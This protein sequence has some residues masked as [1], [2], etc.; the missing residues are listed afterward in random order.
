MTRQSGSP[1]ETCDT[2]VRGSL[3]TP[4][5]RRDVADLNRQFLELGL[6][7]E[8]AGDARFA[9][10]EPVRHGLL[11]TDEVTRGR[12]AACP[13]TFFE[14]LL[15]PDRSGSVAEPGR[16]EDAGWPAAPGLMATRWLSFAHLA[17]FLAWRLA[18]SAPLA[19]RIAL[20]LSPSS[21]LRLNEMCPS[22]LV[23]LATWPGLIRPRWPAHL[24]F[25]AMLAG[26]GRRNTTVALQ[27]AHCVGIC[28][29]GADHERPAATT[30]D[31]GPRRKP[32]R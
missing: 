7:P 12:M 16:V 24:Q 8:L 19:T 10:S 22:Q 32:R 5:V 6:T 31:S 11:E 1:D 9:W 3:L 2:L 4:T 23:Q 29:L 25:W 28:L 17:L 30:G 18:D 26:A 13:F 14:L 20:G 27:W 21:E 15:P